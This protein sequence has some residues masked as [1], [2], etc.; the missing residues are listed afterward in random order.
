MH[1]PNGGK[2][3]ENQESIKGMGSDEERSRPE[4]VKGGGSENTGH[5]WSEQSMGLHKR[6]D[7]SSKRGRIKK[8]PPPTIRGETKQTEE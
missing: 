2:F 3:I 4:R 6:R 7:G 8:E 1:V 5:L